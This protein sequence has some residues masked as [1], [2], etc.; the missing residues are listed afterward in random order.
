[1]N[2]IKQDL[3]YCNVRRHVI[4]LAR[5]VLNSAVVQQWFFHQRERTDIYFKKEILKLPPPW[6]KDEILKKYK[7]VNTKRTWDRQTQWLLKN[8]INNPC[9][10]Y[11]NKILNCVLFRVIN[12]HET[13]DLIGG[14]IDFEK[15]SLDIINNDIRSILIQK[16]LTDSSYVF[17][18]AAYILGGPKVNFGKFLEAIEEKKENNMVIRMIKFVKYNMKYILTGVLSAKNQKDVF[19]VL[20]S[21][22]GIGSFLAYQIFVDM[23]YILDFPFTEH[24][25]VVAGPGCI[26][27]I[28]WIF[29][30]KAGMTNEE[31]LFWFVDNQFRIAEEYSELWDMDILF[32]FLHKKDRRYTL[33]DMENSGACEIDK[34]CRTI[35][36]HKRP[37]QIYK[38]RQANNM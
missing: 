7:F 5:P 23:T 33:M 38:H 32:H 4:Q 11:E 15:L 8:V 22:P 37:K 31:C 25:F 6:T 36:E 9:V 35:F 19:D 17:F 20:S 12:K 26:R 2:E 27:G 1:M 29:L 34:R 21:F 16:E 13:I 3:P 10:S 28:N 18:S 14:W 24:N 30:D